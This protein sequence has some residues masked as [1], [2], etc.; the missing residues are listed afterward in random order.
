M[1]EKEKRLKEQRIIEA[2][3]KNLMGISGRLGTIVKYLGQPI[4][5][6][7]DGSM[8][9]SFRYSSH[10][11]D[12]HWLGNADENEIPTMEIT[13][14]LGQPVQEPQSEEW[15]AKNA[16][17]QVWNVHHL[18][19][20]FDGL[21]RGIHLEIKY[22]EDESELAVHYEGNLVY[23]EVTG[24]L[25]LYVPSVE[26]ESNIDKLYSSAKKLSDKDRKKE[27]QERIQSAKVAKEH[28]IDK[29]RKTWGI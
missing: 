20:H 18:G 29:L 16:T 10:T 2:T 3:N 14:A 23:K 12:Y 8:G 19:Y 27:K 9:D 21:N 6:Q 25:M 13:D 28:W 5:S 24:D 11:L 4:I 7:E 22:L 17:R 1:Y 26:W 15:G